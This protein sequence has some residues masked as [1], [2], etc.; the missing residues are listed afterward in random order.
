[1]YVFSFCL[2]SEPNL[3]WYRLL[4]DPTYARVKVLITVC[5]AICLVFIMLLRFLN[6]RA[7]RRRDAAQAAQGYN[8]VENSEFLDLTD[9]ENPEFRYAK[10]RFL[11]LSIT[12]WDEKLISI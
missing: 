3:I 5:P 1:M 4:Q 9:V 2:L 11:C 7:N 12:V 8:H 6:M 10:V